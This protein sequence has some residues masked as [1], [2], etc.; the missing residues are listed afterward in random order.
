MPTSNALTERRRL[1]GCLYG[2]AASAA[3]VAAALLAF[4]N[5]ASAATSSA[6]REPLVR[7][8]QASSGAESPPSPPPVQPK[9]DAPPRPGEK[10][11]TRTEKEGTPATV[12]DGQQLESIL[13]KNV[14]SPTGEDMGRI[15]DIMVDHSGAVRAAIIDFGGFLGVGTRKIAVDWRLIRFPSDGKT[16]NV[17]VDLTANQLRVAPIFKPGEPVVMLGRSGD[18]PH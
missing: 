5:S 18:S 12:I 14:S 13:G 4:Q 8:S 9:Q 3:S 17:I 6:K 7:V 15:V 1:F 16:N 11:E 2:A 10:S